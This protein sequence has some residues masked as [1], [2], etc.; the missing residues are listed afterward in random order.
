MKTKLNIMEIAYMLFCL[1]LPFQARMIGKV[2]MRYSRT[3]RTFFYE[4]F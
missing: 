1:P 3:V 4:L 2:L